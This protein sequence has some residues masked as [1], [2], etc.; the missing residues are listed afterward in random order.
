[1]VPRFDWS[2]A[3]IFKTVRGK[4]HLKE[5]GVGRRPGICQTLAEEKSK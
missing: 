3:N 2:V 5:T 4:R 1:M